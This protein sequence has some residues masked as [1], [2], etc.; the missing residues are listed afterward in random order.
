MDTPLDPNELH[1]ET[2]DASDPIVEA[3]E[4]VAEESSPA[5]A[6]STVAVAEPPST[7]SR[8]PPELKPS[9]E[10]CLWYWRKESARLASARSAFEKY[11]IMERLV[12]LA[13]RHRLGDRAVKAEVSALRKELASLKRDKSLKTKLLAKRNFDLADQND[14]RENMRKA[15]MAE[16]VLGLYRQI[17][18]KYPDTVCGAKAAARL[19]SLELERSR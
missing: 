6:A 17:A 12:S 13:S 8:L 18:E 1:D 4:Q 14:T 2:P 5:P 3:A 19:R 11:D 10:A 7:G 9:K 16:Q 15:K